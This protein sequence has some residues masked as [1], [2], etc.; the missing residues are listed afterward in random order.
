M[1]TTTAG[2]AEGSGVDG[3]PG[4][5]ADGGGATSEATSKDADAAGVGG[6]HWAVKR[7]RG[8]VA[9]QEGYPEVVSYDLVIIEKGLRPPEWQKTLGGVAT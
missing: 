1:L 5:T 8:R 3:I 7:E 9:N 2:G 4:G 6:R